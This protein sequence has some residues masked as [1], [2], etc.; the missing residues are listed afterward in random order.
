[1]GFLTYP[2][3]LTELGEIGAGRDMSRLV[4]CE[5]SF[6]LIIK[7]EEGIHPLQRIADEA[8]Y[9]NKVGLNMFSAYVRITQFYSILMPCFFVCFWLMLL[10]FLDIGMKQ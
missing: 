10:L 5:S 9:F 7:Y 4:P 3:F 8:Q 6:L 2:Y 1:M